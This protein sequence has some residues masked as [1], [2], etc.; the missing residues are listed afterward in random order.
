MILDGRGKSRL[1]QCTEA[2]PH[3][4]WRGIVGGVPAFISE[5]CEEDFKRPALRSLQ[6]GDAVVGVCSCLGHE[7]A[8]SG[9]S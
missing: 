2:H 1:K 3:I 7:S 6:M 8:K 9:L 5:P 4:H